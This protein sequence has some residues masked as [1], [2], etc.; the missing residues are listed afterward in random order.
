MARMSRFLAAESLPV[1]STCGLLIRQSTKLP[2]PSDQ[3]TPRCVAEIA[4]SWGRLS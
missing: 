3:E 1:F 2:V 4:V